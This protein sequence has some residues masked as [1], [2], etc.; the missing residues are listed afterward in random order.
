MTAEE[1]A[2]ARV[3]AIELAKNY[4]TAAEAGAA[5]ADAEKTGAYSCE[6]DNL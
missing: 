4:W 1:I 6:E 2:K 3:L 5:I